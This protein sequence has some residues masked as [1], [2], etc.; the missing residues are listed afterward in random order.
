MDFLIGL[1]ICLLGF[2]FKNLGL[3]F[4]SYRNWIVDVRNG[5]LMR[6]GCKIWFFG[7][8]FLRFE[9]LIFLIFE[10]FSNN[11]IGLRFGFLIFLKIRKWILIFLIWVYYFFKFGLGFCDSYY[12]FF[13]KKIYFRIW[14]IK[15]IRFFS[16]ERD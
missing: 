6:F 15:W 13:F 5:D 8:R 14:K 16:I 10:I 12:F 7:L 1:G 11:K 4:I 9:I 2:V 3:W